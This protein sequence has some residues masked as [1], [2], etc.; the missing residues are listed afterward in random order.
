MRRLLTA[1]V[2]AAIPLTAIAQDGPVNTAIE[3]R[4]G[5]YQMLG[6]NMG[7][8][9]GMAKGDSAY[10]EVAAATAA[11]NIEALTRYDLPGLFV[12]GSAS[13]QAEDSAAKPAIWENMDDFRAKFKGLADAAAGASDAV[14]GGQDNIGPVLGKLGQACKA[15][16]DVYREKS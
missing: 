5:Y 10:D 8:L 13:G 9:S 2:L 14:K 16:H 6:I 3:A 7:V 11:A 1:A 12:E 4:H 15:C